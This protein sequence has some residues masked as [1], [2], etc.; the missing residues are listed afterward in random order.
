MNENTAT[1]ALKPAEIVEQ[2]V[3][4]SRIRRTPYN[5]GDLIWHEWGN[6]PRHLVLFH[7]GFGSWTHWIR[8][9]EFFARYYTVLAVDMPG[10]GDSADV[11]THEEG[12]RLGDILG[13][14]LSLSL[15]HI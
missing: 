3:S 2:I 10:A 9:I 13:D 4:K 12:E 6:A 11:P 1:L 15:I 5:K 8:N 7:G 14:I